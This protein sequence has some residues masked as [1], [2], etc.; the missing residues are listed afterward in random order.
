MG[1]ILGGGARV[2]VAFRVVASGQLDETH[3]QTRLIETLKEI[4]G[5]ISASLVFIL[6]EGNIHTAVRVLAEL[7]QLGRSQ[8]STDSTGGIAESCLPQH[9]EI[10]QAL[11][12]D[13]VGGLP[14][15]FPGEQAA[16]ERGRR[17]CAKAWPT[18]RPYRLTM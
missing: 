5:G 8:T 18:L 2:E 7:S 14:D 9:G 16:L 17:R 1:K 12:Q 11:D 4:I 6:V 13:Y 10:E 3:V 15:R